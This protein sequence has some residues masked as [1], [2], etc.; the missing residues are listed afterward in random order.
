MVK[1][2]SSKRIKTLRT[3]NGWGFIKNE[4]NAYLYKH[5]IQHQKIVPYTP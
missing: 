1:K 4:F 3:D 5:E 2:Q